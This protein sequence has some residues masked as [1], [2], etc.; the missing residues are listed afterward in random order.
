MHE[1]EKNNRFLLGNAVLALALVAL[2]FMGALWEWLG[3]LA[4]GLWISLAAAGAYLLLTG[5]NDAPGS[6][7]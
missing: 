6:P 1:T 4:M 7:H 2:L 5:K 3:P